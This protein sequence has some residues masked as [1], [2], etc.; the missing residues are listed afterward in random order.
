MKIKQ[1]LQSHYAIIQ[2]ATRNCLESVSSQLYAKNI[3]TAEVRDL[4]D[5][6]KAVGDFESKLS[7]ITDMSELKSHCQVFLECISQGGPA[8]DVAKVLS[9]EWGSVFD[10]ESLLPSPA[11]SSFTPSPSPISPPTSKGIKL[12]VY[13]NYNSTLA[14]Q[15]MINLM[16]QY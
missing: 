1:I 6:S 12:L 10:V 11:S 3:I 2:R 9:A 4:Q 16:C 5:Y 8:D 14:P 15:L 13:N 7:F